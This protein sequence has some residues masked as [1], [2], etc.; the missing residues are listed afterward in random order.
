MTDA[1]TRPQTPTRRPR[2]ALTAT[3]VR[4]ERIAPAMVRVVLG[5]PGLA[6]YAP[7][8]S[9]DSYVKAVFLPPAAPDVLPRDQDDRVDLDALR[10]VL[11]ADQPVRL[12]SYTVRVWD[13]AAG[14][15]TLDFVVHG[16]AG[17]AGPWAARAR[18]G[19]TLLLLG[20][21]GAYSPS[22]D[23]DWHLL[24]ADESA[25]PAAAV[26]LERLPAGARAVAL[27][28]VDGPADEVPLDVPAGAQVRWVHRSGRPVGEAL[29]AEVRGLRWADGVPHA[30]VH[31]EAGFVKELRAHLRIERGVPVENLSVSG[32]W[33]LGA[34]DEGWRAA[35]RDWNREVE[36]RE[37][38]AGLG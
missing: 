5:G 30:F 21:G 28:E 8:S 2:S 32:Y 22:P 27:L 3:V 17:L 10:D 34:D 19:D 6:G 38:A 31:G 1:P 33:R 9:A 24:V 20:P 7:S 11:P 12:R 4:T 16:D 23:A 13:G 14:E 37:A 26:V 29:V 15:L 25:I 35:K 36:E 18:P